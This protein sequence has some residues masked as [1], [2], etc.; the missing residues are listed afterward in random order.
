M[1]HQDRYTAYDRF[2][3]FYNRYWA[4]SFAE[5]VRPVFQDYLLPLVPTGG[6]VLDL[7][8]GTGQIAHWLTGCGFQVTGLDGSEEMIRHARENAPRT[9][10][11]IADARSF[12]LPPTFDAVISTYDSLNHVPSPAHLLEV[13]RNAHNA[14]DDD[15][16]FFFDLNMDEGFRRTGDDTLAFIQQDHVCITENS[17]DPETGVGSSNITMFRLREDG[18]QRSDVEIVERYYPEN[19]VRS[20]LAD[21][22][23]VNV[24]TYDAEHDCG[25]VRGHGRMFFLAQ[26]GSP[27]Q[28]T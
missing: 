8:C 28:E 7:C 4:E 23:F 16:L 20:L 9:E 1:A 5:E 24:T 22:G 12:D 27:P 11:L 15:G 25:M 18:W 19:E 2:A 3:W 14:L 13:F 17:Y 26:K 10:L 6:R 21:A